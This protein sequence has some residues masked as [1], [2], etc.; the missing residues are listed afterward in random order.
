MIQTNQQTILNKSK[1][2]VQLYHHLKTGI[3]DVDA[4]E[5]YNKINSDAKR[6]A[7][8]RIGLNIPEKFA[9]NTVDDD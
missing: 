9:I 8:A 2:A 1:L 4:I 5:V 6:Y 7:R 3:Q